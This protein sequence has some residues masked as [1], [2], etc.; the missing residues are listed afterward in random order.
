MPFSKL[1]NFIRLTGGENH[2]YLK[3][4]LEI[5][6]GSK[7]KMKRGGPKRSKQPKVDGK[8]FK[9]GSRRELKKSNGMK[10]WLLP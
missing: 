2:S 8:L 10:F 1:P 3:I 4:G 7:E 5:R 9:T 6:S